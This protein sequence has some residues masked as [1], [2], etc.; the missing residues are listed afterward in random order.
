MP[1]L[2]DVRF[3]VV[4]ESMVVRIR[5]E[6]DLSNAW[7]VGGAMRDAISNQAHSVVVDLTEV[8]YLDS[9]GIRI[10]FDLSRGLAE[11]DQQ[12]IVV[13][14]VGTTIRR[15]LEV[16]AFHTAAQV[17]ESLDEASGTMPKL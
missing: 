2:A 5:G 16:S 6:V 8:R 13:L 15:A 3:E 4:G 9:A 17:V 7:S 10:L 1:E 14:P 11:H 12:L